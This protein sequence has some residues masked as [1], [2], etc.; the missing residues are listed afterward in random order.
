[1]LDQISLLASQTILIS[2]PLVLAAIH[3]AGALIVFTCAI[4]LAHALRGPARLQA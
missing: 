2:V 1:M 3:Q 4:G